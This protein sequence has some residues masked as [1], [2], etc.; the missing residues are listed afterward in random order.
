MTNGNVLYVYFVLFKKNY[1]IVSC[2]V[3]GIRGNS[4]QARAFAL[5]PPNKINVPFPVR[6]GERG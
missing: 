5:A 4:G 1:T 2:G 6:E 3:G